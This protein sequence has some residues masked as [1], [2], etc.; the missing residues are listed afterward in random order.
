MCKKLAIN[1]INMNAFL[2][3][4]SDTKN[5]FKSFL[6]LAIYSTIIILILIPFGLKDQFEFGKLLGIAALASFILTTVPGD[7]RR[8]GLGGIFRQIQ[9]LLTFCRAQLGILM[10]LL[11]S[12]HYFIVFITPIIASGE[13]P[14]LKLYTTFGAFALYGCF[15]L[16][17]TSNTWAKRVLKQN[18]QKLHSLTYLI[19][20]F[21]FLHV[22]LQSE[23]IL[24]IIILLAALAQVSS[25]LYS[26]LTQPA[27]T[28]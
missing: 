27:K 5:I 8:F 10:F 4:F 20:W 11:A 16:F 2:L 28:V 3:N 18:W 23:L 7:I 14:A 22:A 25:L 12:A 9:I 24:A 21:I 19:M 17:I 15:P 1:Q 26:F 6:K 13:I